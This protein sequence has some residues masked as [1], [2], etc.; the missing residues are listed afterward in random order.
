MC[1]FLMLVDRLNYWGDYV[2]GAEAMSSSLYIIHLYKL[3]AGPGVTQSDE[4][5][6]GTQ[7]APF[8]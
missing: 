1:S 7:T 4:L 5:E 8:L 6:I 2:M 3:N